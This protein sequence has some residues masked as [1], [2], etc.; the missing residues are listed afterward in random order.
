MT[1]DPILVNLEEPEDRIRDFDRKILAPYAAFSRQTRGRQYPQK[2][3]PL[4]SPFQRDRDRVIHSAAFRRMEYKTQV[5]VNHEGDHYRTRLTH[6]IE[7]A[8]ISRT[9]ARALGLNEDL[10]EAIA[11]VHDLGHTPFG[12]SGEEILNELMAEYGGFNHNRQSLH[13]VDFLERRYPEHPGLNLT[14]EVREG[15]VKHETSI[16]PIMPEIFPPDENPTLEASLV[17][18]ADSIAYNSHDVD[19][20]ISSGILIWDELQDVPIW[21]KALAASMEIHPEL[22]KKHRRHSAVRFLVDRQVTD[23]IRNTAANLRKYG[24]KNLKDVR[25]SC[26]KP[27]SFSQ[28]MAKQIVALKGFLENKMYRHSHMLTMAAQAK[29]IIRTIFSRYK[30]EPHLLH[31]KFKLRLDKE[32]TEIIIRDFIAGMTDRYAYRIFEQLK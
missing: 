27:V 28:D 3:H 30:S 21:R 10:A 31:G 15:I 22:E 25:S 23:I 13:V 20:G 2:E 24:I 11:L 6:T 7:V 18:I 9:I 5:F 26:E 32:P 14:Y 1:E 17:D 16:E 19:D 4:R 8:Q 29:T 12:H